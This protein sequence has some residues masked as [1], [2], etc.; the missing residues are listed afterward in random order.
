M[1]LMVGLLYRGRR[2]GSHVWCWRAPSPASNATIPARNS[3]R[4]FKQCHGQMQRQNMVKS[5][6]E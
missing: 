4:K 2:R 6:K 1:K 5:E 3:G